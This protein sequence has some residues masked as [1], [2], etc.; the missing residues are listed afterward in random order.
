MESHE[1]I[2]D[3]VECFLQSVAYESGKTCP[4]CFSREVSVVTEKLYVLTFPAPTVICKTCDGHFLLKYS[5]TFAFN[6]AHDLI[7]NEQRIENNIS[8]L[9]MNRIEGA[10]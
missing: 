6:T 8:R 9:E 5:D 2:N 1:G 3:L 10:K 7:V 4:H